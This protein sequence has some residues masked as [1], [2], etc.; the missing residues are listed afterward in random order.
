MTRLRLTNRIGETLPAGDY[1]VMYAEPAAGVIQLA[2]SRFSLGQKDKPEW[3]AL[4]PNPG[5]LIECL[6]CFDWFDVS[7]ISIDEVQGW[8]CQACRRDAAA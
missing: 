2:P 7:E 6:R 3:E 4:Q 1:E 8:R 5:V